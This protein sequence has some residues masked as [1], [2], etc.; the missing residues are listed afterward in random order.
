MFSRLDRNNENENPITRVENGPLQRHIFILAGNL[1]DL[2]HDVQ[3]DF[4]HECSS[5]RERANFSR[6]D[7]RAPPRQ[8]ESFTL[9]R[10]D[11]VLFT[12][13]KFRFVPVFNPVIRFTQ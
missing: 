11:P 4:R 12:G 7:R 8:I 13:K 5:G 3:L 6:Y 10:R 9:D 2:R 1:E